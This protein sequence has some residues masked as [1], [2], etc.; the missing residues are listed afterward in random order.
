MH[1]GTPTQPPDSGEDEPSLYHISLRGNY[2]NEWMKWLTAEQ[3]TSIFNALLKNPEIGQQSEV[4]PGLY[5]LTPHC[6]ADVRISYIVDGTELSI[7]HIGASS[8]TYQP[9]PSQL[10]HLKQLSRRLLEGAGPFAYDVVVHGAAY[11]VIKVIEHAM[12]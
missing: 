3:Q 1:Q 5:S 7:F 2:C 9:T 10:A 12:K 6:A 11:S 8:V 4:V